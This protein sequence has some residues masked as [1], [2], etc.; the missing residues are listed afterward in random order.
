MATDLEKSRGVIG[1]V[2]KNP[3]Q[4]MTGVDV[5]RPLRI[6]RV[7]VAVGVTSHD[8][9]FVDDATRALSM[10]NASFGGRREL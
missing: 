6:A 10:K 7:E 1:E 2:K 9:H 3:P 8:R 5:K 4:D